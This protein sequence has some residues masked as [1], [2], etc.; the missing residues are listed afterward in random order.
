MSPP[1]FQQDV[2]KDNRPAVIAHPKTFCKQFVHEN[3]RPST[4]AC[5]EHLQYSTRK[6]VFLAH[7]FLD[8]VAL[9]VTPPFATP[10]E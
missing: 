6:P 8:L 5:P 3:V 10:L 7:A 4:S 9:G 2:R 1:F